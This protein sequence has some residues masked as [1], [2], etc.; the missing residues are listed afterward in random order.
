MANTRTTSC[1]RVSQV[2]C[3][4]RVR[5]RVHARVRGTAA[6][7]GLLAGGILLAGCSDSSNNAAPT[8]SDTAS[9]SPSP[10]TTPTPTMT[11]YGTI[12]EQKAALPKSRDGMQTGAV[13]GRAVATNS[14]EAAVADAWL[15]YW[16]VRTKAFMDAKIVPSSLDSVAS[17]EA[18][19]EVV[20]GAK[21]RRAANGYTQGAIILNPT[22]I[23]ISGQQAV[24][25]DCAVNES[26]DV[27]SDGTQ[28]QV[29]IQTF[30]YRI[31]LKEYQNSWRTHDIVRD[32]KL[33][34][35]AG[36]GL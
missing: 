36:M 14:D 34:T 11:V 9:T 21:N 23:T 10:S 1:C 28:E 7:A 22:R 19:Q 2:S 13:M 17:G 12:A 8:P 33:C 3:R 24:L 35:N 20:T 6:L 32:K 18:H 5:V 25:L 31:T 29:G 27:Y 16:Q 15:R 26:R 4:A 30:G